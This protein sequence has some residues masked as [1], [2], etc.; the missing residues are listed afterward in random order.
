MFSDIIKL[1]FGFGKAG[2]FGYGGGV[3][4]IGMLRTIVVNNYGWLTDQEFTD[5][6]TVSYSLPGPVGT[7]LAGIIGWRVAGLLGAVVSIISVILPSLVAMFILVYVFKENRENEIIMG[8]MNG[9]RPVVF[10]LF[11]I[12]ALEFAGFTNTNWITAA[13]AALA[14]ILMQYIKLT[15]RI[16]L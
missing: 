4:V 14:F 6:V 3:G 8:I 15:L 13:V 12:L 10:A 9:I 1:A 5:L 2:L 7:Q 11:A 16:Y